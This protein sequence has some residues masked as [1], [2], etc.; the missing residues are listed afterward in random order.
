MSPLSWLFKTFNV[1]WC[2]K[3]HKSHERFFGRTWTWDLFDCFL[4]YQFSPVIR[5][6]PLVPSPR[7]ASLAPTDRPSDSPVCV[8]WK[9]SENQCF[10]FHPQ[11]TILIILL[12]ITS[13][14]QN[15]FQSIKT[16]LL[17]IIKL[18]KMIQFSIKMIPLSILVNNIG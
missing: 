15:W 8:Y 18:K 14:L 9:D 6:L 10:I 13:T 4:G 17:K 7:A 12:L 2:K 3:M 16:Y 11:Q 5:T 1:G